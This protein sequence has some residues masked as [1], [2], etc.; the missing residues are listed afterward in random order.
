MVTLTKGT[1]EFVPIKLLNVLGNVITLD[2]LGLQHDLFLDDEAETELY[3]GQA[4]LNDGMIAF[5]D[6]KEFDRTAGL[7][8]VPQRFG[9][10]TSL[11]ISRLAHL[12]TMTCLFWLYILLPVGMTY[13]LGVL[14][15]LG[16]IVYE[17]S[18]VRG[19]DLSKLNIAFFNMNGYISVTIFLFTLLD[20]LL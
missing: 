16:L 9:V 17:H 15:A 10:R 5:K 13:L 4:T 1:I 2:G 14:I 6:G 11:L 18:L 3:S 8:S 20:V 12:V 7:H 19:D